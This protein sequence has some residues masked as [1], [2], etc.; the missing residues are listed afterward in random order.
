MDG[1]PFFLHKP[2]P[3][4]DEAE[5]SDAYSRSRNSHWQLPHAGLCHINTRIRD[6]SAGPLCITTVTRLP[7]VKLSNL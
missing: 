1:F 6:R 7:R 2:A 5:E 3:P 4:L